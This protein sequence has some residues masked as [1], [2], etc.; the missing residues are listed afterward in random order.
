MVAFNFRVLQSISYTTS[1][2]LAHVLIALHC[3]DFKKQMGDAA[4]LQIHQ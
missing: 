4:H 2:S 1:S 3:T